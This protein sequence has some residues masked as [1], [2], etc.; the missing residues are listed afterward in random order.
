MFLKEAE[1]ALIPLPALQKTNEA[2]V[3]S[4]GGRAIPVEPGLQS[5]TVAAP[6]DTLRATVLAIPRA[7]RTLPAGNDKAKYS[8]GKYVGL[9]TQTFQRTLNGILRSRALHG[10]LALSA[11]PAWPQQK[12]SDLADSSL[13]DLMN[14]QITSVTQRTEALAAASAVFV[15]TQEDIRRSGATNVPD[16]FRLVPGLD[17]A[18]I[19]GD[20]WAISARGLNLRFHKRA[21]CSNGWSSHLCPL[22]GGVFWDA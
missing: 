12:P 3:A 21:T 9:P 19:N 13:E 2:A 16:L 4:S 10:C 18:Q 1:G 11:L 22:F 15:I 5:P 6:A 20:T 7:C 17:V 8:G 14:I